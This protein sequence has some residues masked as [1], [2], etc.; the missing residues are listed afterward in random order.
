MAEMALQVQQPTQI[1]RR[2][3][4]APTT[5]HEAFEFANMLLESGMIPKSYVGKPPA[6]IVVTLQFGMEVGLAP[7][8]ALQ[9][10]ANINGNPGLWGDAALALVRASGVLESI[11]EDD[12]EVIKANQKATCIVRRKGDPIEKKITF[13]YQDAKDAGIFTNA[14]WKSY[15]Y[16]MAQMRARAFALRDKFPDVLKGLQIVEEMQD[17]SGQTIDAGGYGSQQ[18]QSSTQIQQQEVQPQ[19]QEAEV[20]DEP[21]GGIGAVAWFKAYKASGWTRQDAD[22]FILEKFGIQAPRDSRDIKTSQL[23]VAMKWANTPKLAAAENMDADP[24]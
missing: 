3:T 23:E 4:F 8:Q 5:L 22:A 11:I 12:F 18:I 16:R 10:I 2:Q 9:N 19:E 24:V 20:V 6:A 15:P 13:S 17:Y 21:I 14:V 1:E 7:L